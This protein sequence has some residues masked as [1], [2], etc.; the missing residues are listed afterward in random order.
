MWWKLAGVWLT[1]AIVF[2]VLLL[3]V[4]THIVK[5]DM[6]AG[7]SAANSEQIANIALVMAAVTTVAI[8]F[9]ILAI[10]VWLSWRIVR[11]RKKIN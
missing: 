1:T 4:H 5:L 10:P 7:T 6:P 2:G 11:K 9:A 8:V 3:P